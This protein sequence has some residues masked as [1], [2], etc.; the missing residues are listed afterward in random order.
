MATEFTSKL[1]AIRRE[2]QRLKTQN[3]QLVAK[4]VLA[5]GRIFD[6][7]GS[8]ELD[9]PLVAG[10]ADLG[11]RLLERPEENRSQLKALRE[12]GRKVAGGRKAALA[13]NG[14]D[15]EPLSGEG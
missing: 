10:L 3:A 1:D 14:P 13:V 8:L 7:S 4:R 2:Q 15:A 6:R 11:K 5:I 12:A 9:D